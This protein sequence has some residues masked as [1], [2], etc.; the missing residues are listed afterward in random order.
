MAHLQ[1]A[2]ANS[3]LTVLFWNVGKRINDE[4]PQDRRADYGEKIVP[5]VSA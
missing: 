4:I 5:T 1:F 2:Q 3:T